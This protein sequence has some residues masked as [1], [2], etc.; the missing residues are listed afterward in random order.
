MGVEGHRKLHSEEFQQP[1]LF[2]SK[3]GGH[4]HHLE[5]RSLLLPRC[6]DRPDNMFLPRQWYLAP[7]QRILPLIR[8]FT[9]SHRRQMSIQRHR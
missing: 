6:V 4:A 3:G 1:Q 5:A 8:L 7:F 2:I 9:D